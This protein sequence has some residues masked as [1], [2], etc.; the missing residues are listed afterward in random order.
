MNN[1]T[2]VPA[3][4]TTAPQPALLPEVYALLATA[5]CTAKW[6]GFVWIVMRKGKGYV[7]GPQWSAGSFDDWKSTIKAI[8]D[9]TG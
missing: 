5:G 7:L 1:L 4:E 8:V 2:Q 9:A 6:Q 3:Q